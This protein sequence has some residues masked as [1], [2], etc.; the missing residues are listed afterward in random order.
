[1]WMRAY[2]RIP[3]NIRIKFFSGVDEYY[4]TVTNLSEKGMFIK[5]RVSFP[6]QPRL[7]ILVPVKSEVMKI[8]AITKSFGNSGQI[9]DGIG[10]ELVSPPQNYLEYIGSLRSGMKIFK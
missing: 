2:E 8:S 6:L 5:T 1:M 4:G 10:V 9:Y 3:S 7:K